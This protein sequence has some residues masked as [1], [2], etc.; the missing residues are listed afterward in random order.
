MSGQG[1]GGWGGDC[2]VLVDGRRKGVV[3]EVVGSVV[4]EVETG[5]G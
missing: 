1:D 3:G 2:L 4:T 5:D